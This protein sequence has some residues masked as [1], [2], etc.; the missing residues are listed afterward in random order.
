MT[1]DDR[2]ALLQ[3]ICEALYHLRGVGSK[4]SLPAAKV[5]VPWARQALEDAVR[6][7]VDLGVAASTPDF[8]KMLLAGHPG[9]ARGAHDCAALEE[10]PSSDPTETV[11]RR[12][13]RARKLI[14]QCLGEAADADNSLSVYKNLSRF[15]QFCERA[16]YA[17]PFQDGSGAAHEGLIP[18]DPLLPVVPWLQKRGAFPLDEDVGAAAELY[19]LWCREAAEATFKGLSSIKSSNPGCEVTRALVEKVCTADAEADRRAALA[20]L[21][22]ACWGSQLA[23]MDAREALGSSGS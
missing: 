20:D 7:H 4:I 8:A 16:R 6:R 13:T 1:G 18:D 9:A 11:L 10:P 17:G 2:R 21:L 22:R 12:A 14:A 5:H 23:M 3:A 19:A 15:A